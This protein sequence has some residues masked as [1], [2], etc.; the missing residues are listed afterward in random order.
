MGGSELSGKYMNFWNCLH[1]VNWVTLIV[2][3]MQKSRKG[4]LKLSY[5]SVL[6]CAVS[7]VGLVAYGQNMV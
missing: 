3:E 5:L 7:H 4:S 2:Q 1:K 6:F